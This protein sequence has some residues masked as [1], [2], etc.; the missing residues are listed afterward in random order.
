MK[1]D[2]LKIRY[3]YLKLYLYLLEYISN[4]KYICR[5]KEILEYLLL[6]Y[7]LFNLARNKLKDKLVINYLIFLFLLD[8]N[9]GIKVSIIYLNKIN[10]YTRKYYLVYKLKD[11]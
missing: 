10:I 11:N 1:I 2:P 4:N 7:F 8:I 5:T 6:N 3:R 9:S